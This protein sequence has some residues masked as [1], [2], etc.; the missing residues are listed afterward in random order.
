MKE[1]AIMNLEQSKK[2]LSF[3][4]RNCSICGWGFPPVAWLCSHCWKKL[5]NCYLSPLDMVREQ[6]GLTHIRLFDWRG[7]NDFFIRKLLTSLKKGGPPFIF[8][9][10][11]L[12]FLDRIFQI[13][14]LPQTAVLVPAPAHPLYNFK[15]HAFLL[16]E[17]FSRLS[18]FQLKT[19]L[20]RES[21]KT[22]S[23]KQKTRE[24]RKKTQVFLKEE[25]FIKTPSVI[26]VDD[27]LT[28][29]AT[30]HAVYKTL[31][32]PKDFMIFT[33]TY[34]SDFLKTSRQGRQ[35]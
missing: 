15:D 2:N 35:G 34:R 10:L 5:T 24:E 6:E 32:E 29:G 30:A 27:I 28:T 3:W 14:P 17:A 22:S 4:L 33:L 1:E 25:N 8:N 9:K 31:G 12:A 21:L 16:A 11:V 18:G 19:P 26:F 7:E 13:R 23:Q 20:L